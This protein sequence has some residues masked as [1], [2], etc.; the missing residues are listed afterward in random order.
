MEDSKTGLYDID[1]FA[2]DAFAKDP[3]CGLFAIFDGHGGS[4]VVEYAAKVTPDV[5]IA[6][7]QIFAKEFAKENKNIPLLY[8][9]V[10][11]K[12]QDRLRAVGAS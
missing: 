3:N 2:I 6:P 1:H 7:T 11:Q 8:Q 10:F 5:Q 9:T 12:V 4:E